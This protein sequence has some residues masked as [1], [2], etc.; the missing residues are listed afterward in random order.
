MRIG[1]FVL[2]LCAT[3]LLAAT[4]I[5]LIDLD[6]EDNQPAEGLT[7]GVA[8]LEPASDRTVPQGTIISVEWTAS[9]LTGS[10][11]V[12]AVILRSRADLSETIL[13]G[14]V[15]VTS[16]STRQA[17][18]WNTG[19]FDAGSYDL[20]V[21]VNTATESSEDVSDGTITV[22]SAASFEFT[23]PLS[24][25]TLSAPDPNAPSDDPPPSIIIRWTANDPESDSELTIELDEDGDHAS[26]NEITLVTRSINNAAGVDSF[27]WTGDDEG[28]ERVE[29]GVYNLFARITDTLSGDRFVDSPARITVEAVPDVGE[30]AITAPEEDTS[31]VAGDPPLSIEFTV[32]AEDDALVDV[33]I[34]TDDSHLSGNEQT[35]LSQR[36]VP[37]GTT[38][39][40]FD[41]DGTDAGGAPVADGIYRLFI[42]VSTGAGAPAVVEG[43]GL[44]FRR[45]FAAQPLVGL[46]APATNTTANPGSFVTI[47]WRDDDPDGNDSRVRLVLDDDATPAEG[48][49]TGAGEMLILAGRLASGDDVQDSF[50][51]QVPG[52][53]AP[54]Q[55]FIFA[56]IDR[57]DTFPFDHA[58]VA[59][60]RI[61]IPDPT[62]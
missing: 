8:V 37:V 57:D 14:G 22:N 48:V 15:R 33:K 9:N 58:S 44:V 10:E 39:D 36:L 25:A 4:C 21:R 52:N 56:Y 20:V 38:A 18:D 49:E 34:D 31:F 23:E 47:R 29:G 46:L 51:F 5:P 50:A 28:G 1:F 53:L 3:S 13:A 6:M 55:Y 30:N 27:T 24:D 62:Q 17:L 41:W 26:G 2:A 11:A 60:G 43:D 35:I 40:S 45:S 7:L 61:I 54:G 59:S 16:S 12:A 19:E 42:A 32:G